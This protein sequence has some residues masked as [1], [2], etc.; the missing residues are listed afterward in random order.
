MSIVMEKRV[1]IASPTAASVIKGWT[2]GF[3]TRRSLAEFAED[4]AGA[5]MLLFALM[6]FSVFMMIGL[7]VGIPIRR[8]RAA[9]KSRR[10]VCARVSSHRMRPVAI[11]RV[12][13]PYVPA[14]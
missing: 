13:A 7:A 8:Q 3:K 9:P 4:T 10:R 12:F 1:A 5:I 2:G 6:S 14:M 11:P